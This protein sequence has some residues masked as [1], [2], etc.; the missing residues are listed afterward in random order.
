M[1]V[2]PYHSCPQLFKR[3]LLP[4]TAI[5]LQGVRK[6][7]RVVSLPPASTR[8]VCVDHNCGSCLTTIMVYRVLLGLFRSGL[9]P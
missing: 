2:E 5:N 1:R 8:H 6:V 4:N 9:F 7:N 3:L